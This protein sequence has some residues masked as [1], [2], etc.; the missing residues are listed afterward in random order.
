MLYYYGSIAAH[1]PSFGGPAGQ[2]GAF[3]G[4]GVMGGHQKRAIKA[5]HGTQHHEYDW[6]KAEENCGMV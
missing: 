1:L 5:L 6:T 2:M 4:L 3:A